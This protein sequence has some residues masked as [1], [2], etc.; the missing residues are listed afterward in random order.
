M[1]HNR[2][3][4]VF[5]LTAILLL[6]ATGKLLAQQQ[7]TIE[8]NNKAYKEVEVLNDLG[9]KEY[10]LVEPSKVL[11]DDEII[12]II[13]FKN[14]GDQPASN[15]RITDP[16]PNNSKYKKGSAFGAGTVIEYSIDGGKTYNKPELLKTK[17]ASGAAVIAQT[18]DYTHIRWTY[19]GTLQPGEEGTVT[20]RTVIE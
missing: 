7:G 19:T 12:Y 17:N 5:S 18:K 8:I 10:K 11:P 4:F 1:K 20:F 9:E 3:N 13:T 16:I 15:I 2:I 14:I 6:S